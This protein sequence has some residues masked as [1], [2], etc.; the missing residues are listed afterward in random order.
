MFVEF[1]VPLASTRFHWYLN[2]LGRP[3]VSEILVVEAV[4]V[5]PTC[6]MPLIVGAPVAAV[7]DT[8]WSV[9]V[10]VSL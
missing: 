8:T 4:S 10:A 2:T 6:A 9:K 5:W 1:D 3:L 7:L